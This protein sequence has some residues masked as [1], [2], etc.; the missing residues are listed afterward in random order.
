MRIGIYIG[1]IY[2]AIAF[3]RTLALLNT[4]DIG[5]IPVLHGF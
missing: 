5:L 3:P 4:L 2:V 1:I